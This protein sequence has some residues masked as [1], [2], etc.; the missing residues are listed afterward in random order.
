MLNIPE[1]RWSAIQ[2]YRHCFDYEH[3]P[4]GL[5]Q[6]LMIGYAALAQGLID[7]LPDDA[8]LVAA[9]HDLWE[10]KNAAVFLAVQKAKGR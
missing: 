4:E 7:M 2:K 3:L 5:P 9:M 6:Q 10:S 8:W 1:G